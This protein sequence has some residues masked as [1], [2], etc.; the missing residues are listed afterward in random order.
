MNLSPTKP[1][2]PWTWVFTQTYCIFRD[3]RLD[4]KSDQLIAFHE[5]APVVFQEY[6]TAKEPQLD[7]SLKKTNNEKKHDHFENLTIKL[8]AIK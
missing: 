1:S 2:C 8:N 3:F 4:N 5:S 7:A 6:P